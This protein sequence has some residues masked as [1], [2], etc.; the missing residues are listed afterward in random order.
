L[1]FKALFE[2]AGTRAEYLALLFAKEKPVVPKGAGL[3]DILRAVRRAP[4]S[5]QVFQ[6]DVKSLNAI[7]TGKYKLDLSTDDLK[8]IEYTYYTF[9]KESLDLRFSSIG[10]DNAMNYP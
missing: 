7:L 1:L 3:E 4:S 10:R 5:D 6:R 2:Q 8:K 9:W